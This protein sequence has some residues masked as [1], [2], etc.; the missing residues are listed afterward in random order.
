MLKST[1]LNGGV[2]P[3]DFYDN[4]ISM[5]CDQT[6]AIENWLSTVEYNNALIVADPVLKNYI[7]EQFLNM[8][9]EDISD[10]ADKHWKKARAELREL[11]RTTT[12]YGDS[13]YMGSAKL[14]GQL[15]N[16]MQHTDNLHG[17]PSED[18]VT[19]H[20][21]AKFNIDGRLECKKVDALQDQVSDTIAFFDKV[22]VP[23][24]EDL[25]KIF[26]QLSFDPDDLAKIAVDFSKY[27]ANRWFKR[28]IKVSADKRFAEAPELIRTKPAQ[29]NKA[30]YYAGPPT[31][32]DTNDISQWKFIVSIFKGISLKY[33]MV[34][35]LKKHNPDDDSF[36]V[37]T[38][39][40]LKQRLSLIS[41][42]NATI[43]KRKMDTT[44]IVSYLK[45]LDT[46]IDKIRSKA[47]TADKAKLDDL[48]Q[49]AVGRGVP[50]ANEVVNSVCSMTGHVHRLTNDYHNALASQLR[51]LGAL[52]YVIQTEI[53]SYN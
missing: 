36:P 15:E 34:P 17:N 13:I 52:T 45:K 23:M 49:Q 16:L 26:D 11:A 53:D 27:S 24:I 4:I 5:T 31:S 18:T 25:L 47:R 35:D 37:D 21:T 20:S 10:N 48:P 28:G 9:L 14:A 33:I 6:T 8:G 7:N 44:R 41:K 43:A 39:A 46:A 29:G 32:F 2:T 12:E 51:I 3:S 30:L 42:I 22:Y 50:S 1:N 19:L 40:L 38:A